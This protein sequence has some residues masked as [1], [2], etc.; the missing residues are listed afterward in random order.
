MG[1]VS[2][3]ARAKTQR[4]AI[5]TAAV[6]AALF[7][8]AP[9]ARAD[10]FADLEIV[11]DSAMDEMRGGFSVDGVNFG[12]GADVRT[13]VDGVLALQT[14]VTWSQAGAAV[15]SQ[16]GE[17]FRQGADSNS[18]ST[19]SDASGGIQ[20]SH[21]TMPGNVINLLVNSES[22]RIIEQRAE[23]TI[24]L[25]GFEANQAGWVGDLA[26]FRILTD[27]GDVIAGRY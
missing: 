14:Q 4:L 7:T 26:A 3:P 9:T 25:Y 5:A 22:N 27:L 2:R 16:V 19:A 8:V 23:Y 18:V 6:L 12:I 24:T 21:M 13:L 10:A 1:K 11:A 20:I 17:G 15:A